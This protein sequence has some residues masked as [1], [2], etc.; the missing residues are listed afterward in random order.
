MEWITIRQAVEL[1]NKSESTLRR[2][3]KKSQGTQFDWSKN[4]HMTNLDQVK[5]TRLICKR[6]Y[7]NK[8]SWLIL[9]ESLISLHWSHDGKK[10]SHDGKNDH[11]KINQIILEQLKEKDNQI[12]ELME[13]NRELNVLIK[14]EQEA[15]FDL[16]D[17]LKLIENRYSNNKKGLISGLLSKYGL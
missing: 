9:K 6:K 8:G 7:V 10:Q 17:Q 16:R 13:R 5:M 12:K 11:L 4:S 14:N 2:L 1:S 15:N 3:V